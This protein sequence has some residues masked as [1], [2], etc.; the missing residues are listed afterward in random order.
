MILI[1]TPVHW[2]LLSAAAWSAALELMRKP[3]SLEKDRARARQTRQAS[4]TIRALLELER[5]LD[6]IKES[7]SNCPIWTT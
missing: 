3:Y 7:R 5:Y 1:L 6:R 2:L 4:R